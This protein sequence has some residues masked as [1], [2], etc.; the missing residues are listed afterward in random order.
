MRVRS[1]VRERTLVAGLLLGVS[2][3]AAP[4]T[5]QQEGAAPRIDTPN[6]PSSSRD[7]RGEQSAEASL[8]AVLDALRTNAAA[9]R[10][11]TV[12]GIGNL[13]VSPA[14]LVVLSKGMISL[15]PSTP[16]LEAAVREIGRRWRA[17]GRRPVRIEEFQ[18]A[19]SL[20]DRHAQ[21]IRALGGADLLRPAETDSDGRFS[22]QAVPE[23]RWLLVTDLASP[24]SAL[25]WAIPN[26]VIT[27]ETAVIHLGNG[28][29]LVE[30]STARH[31][32]GGRMQ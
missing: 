7:A 32:E 24:I 21:A 26:R 18:A 14:P 1:G 6:A 25:L 15:I 19:F 10:T 4:Q 8:K 16:E 29:I 3:C 17:G 22:F 11:G 23:G 9:G 28:N 20:L 31:E 5:A 2:A 12:K 13:D 27:G 30:G